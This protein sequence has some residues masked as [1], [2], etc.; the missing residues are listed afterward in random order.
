M[1]ARVV[2]VDPD[3]GIVVVEPTAVP[4]DE[5]IG[6]GYWKDA[7]DR[8]TAFD[9]RTRVRLGALGRW[10]GDPGGQERFAVDDAVTSFLNGHE[11]ALSDLQPGDAVGV[12]Y[13]AF[14]DGRPTIH[15]DQIRAY[16]FRP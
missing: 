14:R 1:S 6:W 13:G 12:S 2:S 3:E 5:L 8:A 15:P 4:E 11:A 7:G 9:A 16:R 10:L